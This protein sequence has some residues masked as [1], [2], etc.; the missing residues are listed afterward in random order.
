MGS[1]LGGWQSKDWPSAA[2]IDRGEPQHVAEECADLLGSFAKMIAW[3]PVITPATL[4]QPRPSPV[5]PLLRRSLQLEQAIA[6]GPALG[7]GPARP[8]R[9]HG[10]RQLGGA[11]GLKNARLDWRERGAAPHRCRADGSCIAALRE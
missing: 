4:P 6:P 1:Q 5:S 3:A 7:R 8:R 2:S 10:G 9:R 11:A